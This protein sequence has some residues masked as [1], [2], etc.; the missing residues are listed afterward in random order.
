MEQRII[1]DLPLFPVL[2]QWVLGEPHKG[3]QPPQ[4]LITLS[5]RLFPY[6]RVIEKSIQGKPGLVEML[7]VVGF[8]HVLIMDG[9]H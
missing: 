7:L 1:P 5:S 9:A 6:P 4:P 8:G 2:D 3:D